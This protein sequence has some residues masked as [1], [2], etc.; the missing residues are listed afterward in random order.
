MAWGAKKFQEGGSLGRKGD[1]STG[2]FEMESGA[3]GARAS[4]PYVPPAAAG[5]STSEGGGAG[6]IYD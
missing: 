5:S 2:L 1:L 3:N 4:A 6:T